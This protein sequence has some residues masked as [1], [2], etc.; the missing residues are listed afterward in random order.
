MTVEIIRH[1]ATLSTYRDTNGDKWAK[2]LNIVSWS[3]KDCTFDIRDWNKDHT[4]CRHGI[5]LSADELRKLAKGYQAFNKSVVQELGG[6]KN[7]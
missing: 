1:I 5:T 7:E 4:V 2:E 6:M 3:G